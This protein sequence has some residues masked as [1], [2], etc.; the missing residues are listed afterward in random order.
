MIDGSYRTRG[1]S[2]DREIHCAGAIGWDGP[3]ID[4]TGP[5]AKL[6]VAVDQAM[7]LHVK[8]TEV[9]LDELAEIHGVD[10]DQLGMAFHGGR[11]VWK[12]I[13]QWFPDVEVQ[14]PVEGKTTKGTADIVGWNEEED[15]VAV[16]DWKLGMSDDRHEAQ[17][18]A[19]ALAMLDEVCEAPASGYILFVEVHLMPARYF[20]HKFT[21]AQLEEFRSQLER[22]HAQAGQQFAPG[23]GCKYCPRKHD[24]QPRDEYLRS[25]CSALGAVEAKGVAPRELLGQLWQRSRDVGRALRTYDKVIELALAEGPILLPDGG[26][27]ALVDKEEDVIDA[28]TA[29]RV[30]KDH[31]MDLSIGLSASKASLKRAAKDVAAKGKAAA[32]ERQV[33]GDIEAMG[34]ISQ[35]T[36]QTVKV[37]K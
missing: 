30:L 28:V 23:D 7:G 26:E 5:E 14:V 6:G 9:D 35:K 2:A 1:S 36:T 24:C 37:I 12:Q 11:Q 29:A 8:G 20:V 17:G 10:R 25:A 18:K 31:D 13:K 19:Y 34:G 21:K 33:L 3:R 4:E 32:L 22:Q 16:A 27:L 15:T